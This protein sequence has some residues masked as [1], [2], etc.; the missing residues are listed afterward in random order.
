MERCR[1]IKVWRRVLVIEPFQPDLFGQ[2]WSDASPQPGKAGLSQSPGCGGGIGEL[3]R[4]VYPKIRGSV[5]CMSTAAQLH[6]MLPGLSAPLWLGAPLGVHVPRRDRAELH[7][8]R[9]SNRPAFDVGVEWAEFHD[10]T[11]LRTTRERT[12]VDLVRYGRHLGG[13]AVAARCLRAYSAAG[14]READVRR[15]ADAVRLPRPA[16]VVLDVLLAGMDGAS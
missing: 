15:M 5:V 6:D 16:R 4:D 7:V 13:S 12:I 2:A 1:S 10:I 9:W 3:L 14:G 11:L 8:L